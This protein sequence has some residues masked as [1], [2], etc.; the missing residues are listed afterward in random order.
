MR[1]IAAH[2]RRRRLRVRWRWVA[3]LVFGGKFLAG[4][5]K[6]SNFDQMVRECEHWATKT[7]YGEDRKIF[8]QMAKAW[9]ELALKEHSAFKIA[10]V[11]DN[12]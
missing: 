3:N 8:L 5:S 10:P 1:L 9:A 4:R 12:L 7:A 2:A 11:A 6:V